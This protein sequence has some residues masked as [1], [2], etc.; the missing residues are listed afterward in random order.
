MQTTNV[1]GVGVEIATLKQIVCGDGEVFERVENTE[2]FILL[3]RCLGWDS[4]AQFEQETGVS[5]TQLLGV[6]WTVNR[7]TVFTM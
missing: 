6:Y 1:N 5:A 4:V 3:L 2:D 7:N